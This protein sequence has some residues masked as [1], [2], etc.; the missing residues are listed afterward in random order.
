M[1]LSPALPLSPYDAA[2]TLPPEKMN[3][4]HQIDWQSAS[5]TS[6]TV[7]CCILNLWQHWCPQPI[8]LPCLYCNGANCFEQNSTP[9]DCAILFSCRVRIDWSKQITSL[10]KTKTHCH[11]HCMPY[12]T[13]ITWMERMVHTQ[14][15]LHSCHHCQSTDHAALKLSQ[16]LDSQYYCVQLRTHWTW[17]QICYHFWQNNERSRGLDKL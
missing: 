6:E 12:Q 9:W 16:C 2:A 14:P 17:I 11:A 7:Y 13:D 1:P 15:P 8:P 5:F 10:Y 3:T 4:C